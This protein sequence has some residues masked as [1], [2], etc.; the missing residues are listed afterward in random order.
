LPLHRFAGE[1]ARMVRFAPGTTLEPRDHPGGEEIFVLE[2]VFED[3]E[4][5]YPAGT[6]IRNPPGSS[7]QAR[8]DEGCLL[9]VKTGHLVG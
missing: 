9:Y 1:T 7:H 3:E 4:G 2:G 8:S 6:W 5:R